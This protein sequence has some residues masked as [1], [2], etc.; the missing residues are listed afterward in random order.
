MNRSQ[1]IM[2]ELQSRLNLTAEQAAGL[3]GRLYSES[4]LN[5]GAFN[6][7]AGGFGAFGLAQHRGA[8]QAGL[9]EYIK[10]HPG[11]SPL[12][13]EVG[14]IIQ[15]LQTNYGGV[16]ADI[17]KQQTLTGALAATQPF[18]GAGGA[19]SGLDFAN[20]ALQGAQ[21]QPRAGHHMEQ[22]NNIVI[23]GATD[24][25]MTAIELERAQD[26]VHANALRNMQGS[27]V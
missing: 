26:R 3:V 9:A 6:N 13:A 14:F 8:R 20:R 21:R 1:Y 19:Y 11:L 15:E 5:P 4:G 16:L 2:G 23:H 12:Q 7:T 22:T 25:K 17:R 10:Q 18:E 24:P 27:W